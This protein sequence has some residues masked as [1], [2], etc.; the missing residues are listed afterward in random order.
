MSSLLFAIFSLAVLRF[1]LATDYCPPLGPVH[2]V[3]HNLS[4]DESI[5]RAARNI[6]ATLAH[7]LDTG[8][9][10]STGF[11]ANTTSFSVNLFSVHEPES[12]FQYHFTASTMNS[13]STKK[14]DENS[15]YRIGS[16]SK[17]VTTFGLLVQGNKVHFDDPITKYIPELDAIAMAHKSSAN[18]EQDDVAMA[19]WS[20]ITVGALAGHLAGIGRSCMYYFGVSMVQD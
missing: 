12:I 7:L 16:I 4:T 13:S 5:R 9:N 11:D 10:D 20:Q 3:P 17:L 6:S 19:Q 1:T 8:A 2:A 18:S 14:V 15:V